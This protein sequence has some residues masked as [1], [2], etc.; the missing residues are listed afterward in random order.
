MADSKT[1]ND[2]QKFSDG[3]TRLMCTCDLSYPE[4][5]HI[6]STFMAELGN[7]ELGF[8]PKEIGVIPDKGSQQ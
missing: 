8:A 2:R 6:V 3:L 5:C 4:F 7:H 1:T